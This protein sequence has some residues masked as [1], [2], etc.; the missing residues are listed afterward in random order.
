MGGKCSP[1]AQPS[2]QECFF[3]L[4]P[5]PKRFFLQRAFIP[6]F[7]TGLGDFQKLI[8]CLGCSGSA[9]FGH[10]GVWTKFQWSVERVLQ[11]TVLV[12]GI[13]TETNDF[14]SVPR[15][16][17]FTMGFHVAH[18]VRKAAPCLGFSSDRIPRLG[19]LWKRG[20]HSDEV[21]EKLRC[22]KLSIAGQR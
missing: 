2:L 20:C 6:G 9:A 13:V 18:T 15:L 4:R 14:L 17:A 21:L 19:S 1:A 3:L 10:G 7:R 11:H 16:L 8:R 22:S 12:S 5:F